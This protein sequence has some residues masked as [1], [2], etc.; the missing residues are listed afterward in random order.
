MTKV[1]IE[2]ATEQDAIRFLE[3]QAYTVLLAYSEPVAAAEIASAI[4]GGKYPAKLIRH[5]LEGSRRFARIDQRWDLEVRYEDKQRPMERVLREVME[6]YGQPITLKTIANELSQVYERPAEYYETLLAR[7][8]GNEEKYFRLSSGEYGLRDWLL[9]VTSDLEED[10]IYENDLSEDEIR[11]L[12]K[13]A[14]KVD[15]AADEIA[16][17]VMK[18]IDAVGSPVGNK[19]VSFFRWRAVRWSF[20][21]AKF[22][23]QLWSDKGLTPL[24]DCRW[25]TKKMIEKY[26]ELLLTM[27]QRIKD[28]V[29]EEVRP[30]AQKQPKVE[31][32]VAPTLALTISERDLDEV[33]Q[34]VSKA[35]Q[36]RME[37]IMQKVF[38]ISPADEGYAIAAQGLAEAMRSDQRFVWLGAD[39]WMMANKVPQ[40]VTVVPPSLVIP[41]V[42]TE[43]EGEVAEFELEDEGLEGTLAV[44]I[45]NPLVQDVGDEEPVTDQDESAVEEYARCVLKY[46]HRH[47]GTFPLCQIPRGFFPVGPSLALVTLFDE[48]KRSDVWV[49]RNTGIIYGMAPFYTEEMAESGAVFELFRTAKPDEFR[50]VYEEKLEPLVFI[51]SQRMQELHALR[52]EIADQNLST[53]DVLARVM[54]HHKKG[55][56]FVTLFTELNVVRRVRRRLVA[57]ILSSYYAFYQKHDSPLWF[58][59]EKKKDQGFKKAKKK[60]IRK[61]G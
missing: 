31:E 40:E 19:V 60:Y 27:A 32:A 43:A 22:Y 30:K 25:A 49:N 10:I 17:Q 37:S 36:A 5:V 7:L 50:F 52:D 28:E 47:A 8:L 13:Q 26:S 18:F 41:P 42:H 54:A 61:E 9:E 21:P 24:S 2:A 48:S 11:A 4:Q 56:E 33:A 59:D 57:S 12:E 3:D 20:D 46:H 45:K 16:A 53:F 55:V 6:W 14:S 39:R 15:W 58:F 34:I 38:E 35:G 29:V 23:D 44:E 1:D 51:S